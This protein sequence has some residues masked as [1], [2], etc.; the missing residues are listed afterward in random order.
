[1]GRVIASAINKALS[2]GAFNGGKLARGVGVSRTI[3]RQIGKDIVSSGRN[4]I[5]VE[6][7]SFRFMGLM[8]GPED[9]IL[10]G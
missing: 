6:A 4:V 9:S 1:M 3:R 2:S 8:N 7:A 5:A 10:R